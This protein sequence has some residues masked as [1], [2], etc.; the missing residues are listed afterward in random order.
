MFLCQVAPS[1]KVLQKWNISG[2]TL[3][4]HEKI[5]L[6]ISISDILFEI[7]IKGYFNNIDSLLFLPM[8]PITQTLL[9]VSKTSP[10]ISFVT[11]FLSKLILIL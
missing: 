5:N 9:V 8:T 10:K 11:L 1:S 2:K 6:S 4:F 7:E 3:K